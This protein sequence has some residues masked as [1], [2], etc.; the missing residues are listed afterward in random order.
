MRLLTV[1]SLLLFFTACASEKIVEDRACDC[2]REKIEDFDSIMEDL[3]A[4]FIDKG[5]LE[6]ADGISYKKHIS[7]VLADPINA[8]FPLHTNAID[9][10]LKLLSSFSPV[11]DCQS[12]NSEE[13][14]D[15]KWDKLLSRTLESA[16]SENGVVM[17]DLYKA[18][19]DILSADD[20]NHPFYKAYFF[21]TLIG[22]SGVSV[23][24]G[25]S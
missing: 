3:E 18:A 21:T 4:F 10:K 13:W 9:E 20:L 11:Y 14:D 16:S 2:Y 23:E 12:I 1:I 7:S 8:N 17:E 22:T 24:L 5:V 6:S 15:S 25:G 19:D